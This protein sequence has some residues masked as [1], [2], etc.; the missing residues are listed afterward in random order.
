MR[1]SSVTFNIM[2]IIGCV[3]V[4]MLPLPVILTYGAKQY[5]ISE[6]EFIVLCHV[7]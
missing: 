4:F 5:D 7:R 1:T 3:M 6:T 2:I